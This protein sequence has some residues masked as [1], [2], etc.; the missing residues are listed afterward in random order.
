MTYTK[1]PQTEY[2]KAKGQLRLQLTGVFSPFMCYGLNEYVSG[3]ID[4][5]IHLAEQFSMRVRGKDIPI[6]M[7][8]NR[9]EKPTA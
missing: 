9:R 1:I 6:E 4:E 7:K 8:S 2:N 5:C 3:A